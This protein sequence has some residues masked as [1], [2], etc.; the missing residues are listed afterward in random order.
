MGQRISMTAVVLMGALVATGATAAS[1][2]NGRR[3]VQ[4]NCA[5]CHA[6]GTTGESRYKGAPPFRELHDRYPMA[7]LAEALAEGM[8]TGHPAMPV[9][10][11]SPRQIDDIIAYLNSVQTP[12]GQIAYPE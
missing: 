11:F 1:P 7:M 5:V 8:L 9:F 2:A 4:R 3:L 6:V 12:R 10:K